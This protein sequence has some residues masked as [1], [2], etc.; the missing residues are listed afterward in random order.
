[1]LVQRT[2]LRLH[3]QGL[4]RGMLRRLV[5]E[6]TWSIE[7]GEGAGLRMTFPQNLDFVRGTS[8]PPM[9]RCVTS[10]LTEGGTFYDVGANVGFFSLLAARRVGPSGAVYAFEPVDENVRAIRTNAVLNAFGHVRVFDVAVD[11][12]TGTRELFLTGWDGGASLS[13]HAVEVFEGVTRRAVR[14]VA[15][16][17]LIDAHG[18]RPPTL[19]KIDVEGAELSALQGMRKTIEKCKPILVYE[20][21]DHDP[22]VFAQRQQSLDQ[23]VTGLGYRVTHHEQS[24]PGMAW[25]VGHSLALPVK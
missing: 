17:D 3:R 13:S 1:M 14:T 10:H 16:D 12:S 5:E 22:A 6:R 8:E 23:F 25:Q 24:Y 18:L 21:D 9:Q 15:L 11:A 7:T 19:V 20:V 2:L 4:L